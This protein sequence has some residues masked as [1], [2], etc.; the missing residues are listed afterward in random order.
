MLGSHNTMTYLPV[1]KWWMKLIS[2]TAKCQEVDVIEQYNCGARWFD[3][4]IRFKHGKPIFAHGLIEYKGDV[5]EV[6]NT[7]NNLSTKEDFIY[8]RILLELNEQ[9][10]LQEMK[11]CAHCKRWENEFSNLKFTGGEAKYDWAKKVEF[12]NKECPTL[13][14]CYSSMPSDSTK[15]NDIF[16]KKW[17]K[18]YNKEAK[19]RYTN[20]IL[21]FVNI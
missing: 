11:F 18:K 5:T 3:L 7:L 10:L 9:D 12:K 19:Q 6:L 15:L 21:D 1:R 2:W 8:V 4:R 16:P 13:I 20:V 17:A 14:E